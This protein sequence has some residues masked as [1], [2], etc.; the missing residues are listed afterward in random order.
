MFSKIAQK[1][2]ERDFDDLFRKCRQFHKDQM[3][4]FDSDLD[5]HLD[6]GVFFTRFLNHSYMQYLRCSALAEVCT[7]GVLP[8]SNLIYSTALQAQY[9][10][11]K[12][13]LLAL[14]K[15]NHYHRESGGVFKVV[16]QDCGC[17]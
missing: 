9:L 7:L 14:I 16:I 5:H 2:R 10:P 4:D 3:V 12:G 17:D 15:Q 11:H 6:S 8:T 1:V 13:E